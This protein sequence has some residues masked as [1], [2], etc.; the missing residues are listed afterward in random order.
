MEQLHSGLQDLDKGGKDHY[1]LEIAVSNDSEDIAFYVAV[2]DQAI[3]LF[4]KQILSLYPKAVITEQQNDYN[5]FYPGGSDLVAVA[6]L[7]KNPIY[8][9]RTDDQFEQDP[10]AVILNAFSKIKRGE[11]GA[12]LQLLVSGKTKNYTDKY[13]KIIKKVEQGKSVNDAIATSSTGGQLML[14]VRDT[15]FNKK[16]KQTE[17]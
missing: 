7:A 11:G 13:K 12:A 3:A 1:T 10:L 5:I 2:P 6:S 15:V 9:L 14:G 4:E 17:A 16:S 8:P